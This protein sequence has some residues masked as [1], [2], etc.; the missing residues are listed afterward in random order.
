VGV[1]EGLTERKM[2]ILIFSTT[3]VCKI[4]R[5]ERNSLRCY[6]KFMYVCIHVK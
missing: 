5:S 6:H 4:S 1:G 3:F 2:C